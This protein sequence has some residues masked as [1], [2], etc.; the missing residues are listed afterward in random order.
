[1]CLMRDSGNIVT[2]DEHALRLW[3]TTKQLKAQHHDP[4]KLENLKFMYINSID[5]ISCFVIIFSLK[6]PNEPDEKGGCMRIYSEQLQLLQEVLAAMNIDYL[7]TNPFTLL[8]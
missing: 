6:K 7:V 8:D 4:V 5:E 3:S 2:Y 1:M